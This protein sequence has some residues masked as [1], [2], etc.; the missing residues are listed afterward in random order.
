MKN[1][2]ENRVSAGKEVRAVL[3]KANSEQAITKGLLTIHKQHGV[4]LMLLRT[5]ALHQA[6]EKDDI[7][8]VELI[9]SHVTD[10][11]RS[12]MI[13]S[14][15][16]AHSY[17]PL[18]RAAY[19][20][21]IRLLKYLVA[22]GANINFENAHKENAQTCIIAGLSAQLEHMPENEIFLRERY[23]ECHTYIVATQA[24]ASRRSVSKASKPYLPPAARREN[25]A[26]VIGLWWRSL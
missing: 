18:C 7:K 12:T 5:H 24:W 8:L 25:A 15:M 14:P 22:A 10:E 20:G 21:S 3:N 2:T 23:S 11:Q 9:L 19:L 16:G 4:P 1:P 6:T 17:T 26:R 13:N